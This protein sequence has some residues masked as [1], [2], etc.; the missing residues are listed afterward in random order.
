L[1]DFDGT[2]ALS[3]V[4]D[5]LLERFAAPGWEELERQWR[6]GRIGS[7]DC[8]AGQ[9]ALIDASR[10]ELDA[11][12]DE[13][14][15]DPDFAAFV[16]AARR[17]GAHLI[18]VSDGLDYAIERLLARAGLADLDIVANQLA[19]DYVVAKASLQTHCRR[20]DIR[21]HPIDGFVDALALLPRLAELVTTDTPLPTLKDTPT[22]A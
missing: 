2:I 18:V 20:N 17:A 5:R 1:C 9:V 13:V 16:T 7:A 15:L 19:A 6:D 11:A 22:H 3:D 10:S 21:H 12:I 14:V 4:T 8:M